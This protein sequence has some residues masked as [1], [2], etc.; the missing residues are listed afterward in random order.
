MIKAGVPYAARK[1]GHAMAIAQA[2][3]TIVIRGSAR[4]ET[5]TMIVEI[6]KS[7]GFPIAMCAAL[8]YMWREEVRSHK[9]ES[10]SFASALEAN[11]EVLRELKEL[12]KK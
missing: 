5:I 9:E 7:V 3:A 11:T 4:M 6:V 8:V 2:P 1:G 10:T 12:I